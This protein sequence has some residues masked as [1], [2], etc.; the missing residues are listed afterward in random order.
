MK[1]MKTVYQDDPCGCWLAAASM[2]TGI[3]YKKLKTE[4]FSSQDEVSGRSAGP[5]K[6]LLK[7]HG[8][9]VD[10]TSTR[11]SAS[12]SLQSLR[13]DA[14]VYAKAHF[15]EGTP[16]KLRLGKKPPG[17][18]MVWDASEQVLRDPAGY[19]GQLTVELRNFREVK[20]RP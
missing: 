18:W 9:E 17:H 1:K 4:F 5:L 20:R 16:V 3:S 6:N 7:T 8:V 11:L 15:R 2:L 12:R 14:L 10:E 19:D 13:R